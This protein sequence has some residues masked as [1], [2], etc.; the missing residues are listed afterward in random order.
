MKKLI[1]L[2]A[3]AAALGLSG[4]ALACTSH[5]S[6]Q[7]ECL[8][9]GTETSDP[10]TANNLINA[11]EQGPFKFS[12]TTTL[13]AGPTSATCT[14]ELMGNVEVQDQAKSNVPGGVAYIQV[15]GGDI[16]GGGTCGLLG[17]RGFPW[18]ATLSGVP[19]VP[20]E[21]GGDIHPKYDDF[22]IADMSGISVTLLGL[23]LC[24]G[25]LPNIKFFNG[26]GPGDPSYFDF[27]GSF[28]S[29]SVTGALLAIDAANDVDAW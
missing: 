8:I 14:L 5:T 18:E 4:T 29:C 22:A 2:S 10:M 21:N 16:K 7:W 17:L 11:G 9:A 1:Q 15:T 13:L 6:N 25:T 28:G 23:P 26:A 3:L 19:G 12:G 27:N 20:G 24:S